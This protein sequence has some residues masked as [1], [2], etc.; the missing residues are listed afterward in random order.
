[1]KVVV[2]APDPKATP[3]GRALRS[4]AGLVV[5]VVVL[6]VVVVTIGRVVVTK[7]AVLPV[8]I[9]DVGSLV[10]APP[11]A[12]TFPALTTLASLCFAPFP[13]AVPTLRR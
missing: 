9:V 7:S 3:E 4:F 11:F 10:V 13:R 8:M 12:A 5:V 6:T 1:M 2:A